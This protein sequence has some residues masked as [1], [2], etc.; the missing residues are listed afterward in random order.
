MLDTKSG[1]LQ[2]HLETASVTFQALTESQIV[3][4][5]T[6]GEPLGKAGGYAIQGEGRSLIAKVDGDENAVIGLPL[7]VLKKWLATW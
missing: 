6:T 2:R 7:A 5:V 4:Y 3:D 1:T